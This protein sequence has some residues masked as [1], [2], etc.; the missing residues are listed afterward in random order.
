ME[1]LMSESNLNIL[2]ILKRFQ[3]VSHN[4]LMES[5]LYELEESVLDNEVK[6]INVFIVGFNE[7]FIPYIDEDENIILLITVIAAYPELSLDDEDIYDFVISEGSY[8]NKP[9]PTFEAIINAHNLMYE[10][11]LNFLNQHGLS[12]YGL[13]LLEA[14]KQTKTLHFGVVDYV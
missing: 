13:I 14:N 7:L 3:A 11:Y 8:T 9:M 5:L 10:K 1:I 2:A 6:F 4:M 12:P